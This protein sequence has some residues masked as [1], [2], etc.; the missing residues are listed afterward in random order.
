MMICNY[1]PLTKKN[2]NVKST[3]NQMLFPAINLHSKPPFLTDAHSSNA[4]LPLD[5]FRIPSWGPLAALALSRALSRDRT[6]VK[7]NETPVNLQSAFQEK[8]LSIA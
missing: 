7:R 1:P 2:G 8:T 3:L 4:L 5:P 6:Q